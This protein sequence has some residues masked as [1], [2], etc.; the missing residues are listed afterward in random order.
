MS[1][2]KQRRK[3]ANELAMIAIA[4]GA[5]TEI[6]EEKRSTRVDCEWPGKVRCGFHIDDLHHGGILASF[7]QAEKPLA[8][9]IWFDSVNPYHQHKATLYRCTSAGFASAFQRACEAVAD[10]RAFVD[11]P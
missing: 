4:S 10:G 7:Y 3:L 9:E 1:T 8:N 5:T 2:K 6:S 11:G